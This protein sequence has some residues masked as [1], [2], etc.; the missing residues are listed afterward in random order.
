MPINIT[1]LDKTRP[2]I[3]IPDNYNIVIDIKNQTGV[4]LYIKY[5]KGDETGVLITHSVCEKDDP[6]QPLFYDIV[7]RDSDGILSKFSSAL[8]ASA[9]ILYPVATVLPNTKVNV[10]FDFVGAT[11]EGTLN[12]FIKIDN[13]YYN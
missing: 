6:N 3:T 5:T 12:I 7:E 2:L 13:A 8:T 11:T 9:N 4:V 1:N 10:N